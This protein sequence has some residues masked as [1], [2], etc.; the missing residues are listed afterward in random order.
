M[1]KES[2]RTSVN[3][4]SMTD[5]GTPNDFSD[6]LNKV[7]EKTDEIWNEVGVDMKERSEKVSAFVE[8]LRGSLVQF[9]Q[10]V[11]FPFLCVNII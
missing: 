3:E 4:G 5:D 7:S 1:L 9:L 2:F 11:C 8:A 6:L 10:S